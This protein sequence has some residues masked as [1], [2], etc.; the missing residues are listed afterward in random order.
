MPVDPA[1][2]KSLFLELA[3]I[4]EPGDRAAR[5]RDRCGADAELFARVGALLAANDRAV[6][7]ESEGPG[8][9]TESRFG[10]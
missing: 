10:S 9:E 4:D 5:L 3:A 7:G 1:V 8:A 6:L 2:V